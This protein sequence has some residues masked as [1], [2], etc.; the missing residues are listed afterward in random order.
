[1]AVTGT[2]LVGPEAGTPHSFGGFSSVVKIRGEQT[3][4]AYSI[5]EFVF[6]PG[7][8]AAPHLHERTDEVSY[9]LEGELGAMVAEEEF[10]VV[11]G[12]FVVRPRGVPHALWNATSQPVRGLDIYTPGGF[13][14]FGEE[15]ARR[16]S[17]APPTFEQVAEFG[18]LHDV[19]FLP[20]LAPRLVKKY[21]LRMPG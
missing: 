21:N 3:S 7:A 13:E 18:R 19:I 1:M 14:A 10:R 6:Q 9:V 17:S 8:F 4:G 2:I 11:A 5:V 20:E 15:L 12:A 16:F